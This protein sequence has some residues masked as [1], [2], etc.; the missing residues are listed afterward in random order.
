[1]DSR[2]GSLTFTTFRVVQ[3]NLTGSNDTK[4]NA[5]ISGMPTG[6]TKITCRPSKLFICAQFTILLSEC[7][8]GLNFHIFTSQTVKLPDAK[9][10][11]FFQMCKSISY[12][13]AT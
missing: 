13:S 8:F 3:R 1:M 7:Y 11:L 12:T 6:V 2:V 9:P 4:P 10:G 5:V